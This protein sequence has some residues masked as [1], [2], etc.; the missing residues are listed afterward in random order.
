MKLSLIVAEDC[1]A[2]MRAESVLRNVNL[3]TEE[4]DFE[5]VNI[6][7]YSGKNIVIVPTLLINEEIFS[8]GEIDENKLLKIL[9]KSLKDK[10]EL[11]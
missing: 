5:I 2:C 11:L 3:Q 7:N 9:D 8:Y 10:N 6:N 4:L 1:A